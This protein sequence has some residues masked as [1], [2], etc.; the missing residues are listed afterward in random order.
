MTKSTEDL[1]SAAQSPSAAPPDTSGRSPGV[2]RLNNLPIYIVGGIVL[3][4][5]LIIA[6][7]AATKGDQGLEA[8]Q[9][10]TD[11][12]KSQAN[13][14]LS[15]VPEG[16]LITPSAP[17]MPE[18]STEYASAPVMMASTPV[19]VTEAPPMEDSDLATIRQEK[20]AAFLAALR[21]PMPVESSGNS[22]GMAVGA[23]GGGS[24]QSREEMLARIRQAQNMAAN[25]G[26]MNGVE[27]AYNQRLAQAG[28][29][30]QVN[31]TVSDAGGGSLST[32]PS[33]SME[34]SSGI[35]TNSNS[36]RL[37]SQVEAPNTYMLRTGAV[38]PATS[39]T[40]I[41][42]DLPGMVQAQISQN[43]YDTATGRY[44]LI[45]QGSRL[46][47]SYNS[48]V[49]FGQR[50]LFVAWNRIIFPDGKAID[51]GSMPGASGAGYSGFHDKVNNHYARIWGN[52]LMLSLVTA[53][54]TYSTDANSS[55][56]GDGDDTTVSG[57]L[58]QAL[59][60]TF[61]Q[62]VT[63]SI[64]RNM[65]ISPTLEIRPGYRFNVI[66]TQDID[67]SKPYQSFDY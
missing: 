30:A 8:G 46:V 25:A 44:I 21:A 49:Q 22:S 28:G 40:G 57:S 7:V 45:P 1:L 5:A 51:I 29:L 67:F 16:G 59:G 14:I 41:N 9:E 20:A 24:P 37:N 10:S 47:G 35:N 55:D 48:G 2:R 65:N 11:N 52:A 26:N 12:A 33:P 64:N 54:I 58:S 13:S 15:E 31:G 27:A 38:L 3:G 23:L 36:W 61:G 63:Q 39:I 4:F 42:S 53:A 18:L 43:V 17:S 62:V 60:Q 19:E 50:R 32:P 56:N 34:Q 66:V 6:L